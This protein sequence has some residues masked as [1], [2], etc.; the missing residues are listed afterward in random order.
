LKPYFFRA[1][2]TAGLLGLALASGA[3]VLGVPRGTDMLRKPAGAGSYYPE[4]PYALQQSVRRLNGEAP[5]GAPAGKLL[6]VLTPHAPFGLAGNAIAAGLKHLQTGQYDRVFVLGPSQNPSLQ[7]CSVADVEAYV[8]PLGLVAVDRA[9]VE[10]LRYSPLIK[11]AR[12]DYR[13]GES[14]VHENN[15]SVEVVLPFLQERIGVFRLV[16]IVV[17]DLMQGPASEVSGRISAVAKAV[18]DLMDDRTLVVATCNLTHYG[19][20]FEF[21]P[22]GANPEAGVKKLDEDILSMVM[23]QEGRELSRELRRT[24]NR[25]SGESVL[26]VLMEVLP[27]SCGAMVAAYETS[28]KKTG[29]WENSISFGTVLFYDSKVQPPQTRPERAIAELNAPVPTPAPAESA[30]PAAES[31]PLEASPPQ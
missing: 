23:A 4:E 11:T 18:R 15:V 1:A 26:R 27:D 20:V 9:A 22:F 10:K 19:E 17:G 8:T 28:G 5:G 3:Q 6:A 14:G 25:V 29:R 16:P 31:A 21:T 7:E 2:L 12:M 30:A 24:Q 13:R